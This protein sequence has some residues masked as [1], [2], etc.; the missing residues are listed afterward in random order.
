MTFQTALNNLCARYEKYGYTRG[1]LSKLLQSGIIKQGF[2]IN[3]SFNGI[4]LA[5]S[6]VTGEH[7]IFTSADISEITGESEQE[8]SNRIEKYRRELAAAGENPDDY[9]KPVESIKL[10]FPHGI[11]LK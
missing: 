4:R 9:F 6:K 5:L 2:S 7:E 1:E 10:Y 11:S 8:L 3:M